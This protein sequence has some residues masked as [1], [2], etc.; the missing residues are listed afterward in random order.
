VRA[1]VVN[2]AKTYSFIAQYYVKKF[3]SALN[4]RF[5]EIASFYRH[6]FPGVALL[7]NKL[8]NWDYVLNFSSEILVG[9]LVISVALINIGVFKFGAGK[10]FV[11]TDNSLAAKL[12]RYHPLS[13]L[14]LYAKENTVKTTISQDGLISHAYADTTQSTLAALDEA[15]DSGATNEDATF[16]NNIMVKPNP[17]S[18]QDLVSKQVVI[19]ETKGGDTLSSI[20]NKFDIS[21]NTIK[22]A[23][24]LPSDTVKPGW[25]LKILPIDGVLYQVDSNDTLPDI[26]EYFK[27]NMETI[28]SYNGLADAEDIEAGQWIIVPNGSVPP[29]PA[30]IP[31]PTAPAKKQATRTNAGTPVIVYSGKGHKFPK[32]YCTW[33]VATQRYVPWGG[34]A[35]AW[36]GN[37]KAAGFA[38]GST[39][40]KN[41]IMVSRESPVGHVALVLEVKGGQFKVAEMNYKG[42]GVR[43]ERW[44]PI[45]SGV[46][47][48]F[49]Y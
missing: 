43:S 23:N 26:A 24:N 2:K 13:N 1:W 21:V 40:Q 49:I 20:A 33:F 9:I 45:G 38:T 14:A 31:T 3:F 32:G 6:R 17:D 39:P 48:G 18:I 34:N 28:I 22:W 11:Y 19:Y 4:R 30:P 44:I 8:D 7:R 37:A 42:F 12:L 16:S 36:L 47:K 10:E 5:P 35:G 46:I 29:P 27:G 15:N 25:F 41:A